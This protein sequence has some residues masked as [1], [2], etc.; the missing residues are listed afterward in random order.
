M[1]RCRFLINEGLA[2]LFECMAISQLH[3]KTAK[4][5]AHFFISGLLCIFQ[6]FLHWN[7]SNLYKL[8]ESHQKICSHH[9]CEHL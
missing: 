7:L 9:H 1:K 6:G 2:P 4:C 3:Y 5:A 8:H